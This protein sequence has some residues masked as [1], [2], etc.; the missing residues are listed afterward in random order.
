M[1]IITGVAG[2]V[3]FHD[4]MRQSIGMK[5][6]TEVEKEEMRNK[7]WEENTEKKQSM[8]L[9]LKDKDI[10]SY[11]ENLDWLHHYS[12]DGEFTFANFSVFDPKE[13][14]IKDIDKCE[15]TGYPK[16][17]MEHSW[18]NIQL[19]KEHMGTYSLPIVHI[20]ICAQKGEDKDRFPYSFQVAFCHTR[21]GGNYEDVFYGYVKSVEEIKQVFELLGFDERY[22]K[23]IK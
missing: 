23:T 17:S 15:D 2:Y 16:W 1:Q 8:K 6:L 21:T 7:I 19:S 5:P 3:N 20:K 11:L 22:I 12:G 9:K 10:Q 13:G 14:P 18:G 4:Y